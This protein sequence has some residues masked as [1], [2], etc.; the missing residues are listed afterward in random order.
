MSNDWYERG[1]PPQ[2]G[3]KFKFAISEIMLGPELSRFFDIELKV[4]ALVEIESG[5]VVSFYH[6]QKGVG[7][8]Y[9]S[10]GDFAPSKSERDRTI[11]KAMK[12]LGVVGVY[13]TS[14]IEDRLIAAAGAWYDAGL[15]REKPDA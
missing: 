13:C 9:F 7:S 4:I 15:L 12:S 1:D 11:E 3:D 6:R 2:V 14:E 5:I 8:A 10:K